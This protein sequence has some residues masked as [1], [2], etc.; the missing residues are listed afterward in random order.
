MIYVKSSHAMESMEIAA[1]SWLYIASYCIFE[2]GKWWNM[3]MNRFLHDQCICLRLIWML[4]IIFLLEPCECPWSL[5]SEL[6]P[7]WAHIATHDLPRGGHPN[8]NEWAWNPVFTILLYF[9]SQFWINWILFP[10]KMKG[11]WVTS[12]DPHGKSEDRTILRLTSNIHILWTH[13]HQN[14]HTH[15]SAQ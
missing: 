15:V 7:S 5:W 2:W 8:P 3:L 1:T 13:W 11:F 10:R 9:I 14:D 4:C 12:R 6:E